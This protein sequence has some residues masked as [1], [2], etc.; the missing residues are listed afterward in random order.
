MIDD[1][2]QQSSSDESRDTK[3]QSPTA[4]LGQPR[5]LRDIRLLPLIPQERRQRRHCGT[6][7]L[8]HERSEQMQH[9]NALLNHLI[10]AHKQLI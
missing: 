6:D 7:V 4:A 8:C 10:G 3:N 1:L 5:Q 2:Q 9:T